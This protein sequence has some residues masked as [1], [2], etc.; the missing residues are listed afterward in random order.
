MATTSPKDADIEKP[1]LDELEY[2]EWSTP[3]PEAFE[4][5]PAIDP[6]IWS[7]PRKYYSLFLCC[8]STFVAAY[9]AGAYTSGI[10]QMSKEWDCSRV[11][12]LLGVTT[13]VAGFAVTP[14]ALAPFSETYGRVRVFCGSHVVFCAM[15]L[16]SALVNNLPGMLVIRF[17][18]GA[19]SSAFSSISGGLISD[20]YHTHDRGTPMAVFSTL[21]LFGTG[22]GPL[23]AGLMIGAGMHWRWIHWV[24]LIFGGAFT[25]LVFLT[26]KET[27][28]SVLLSRRA[29]ALNQFLDSTSDTPVGTRY[30]AHVDEAR[31]SIPILVRTSLTRPF[32]MLVTEPVVFL[33]S[34]WTGLA[35]GL[36]YLFLQGVPV[37]FTQMHQFSASKT[38]TVFISMCG[39][40]LLAF[41]L[42]SLIERYTPHKYANSPDARLFAASTLGLFLPVG[43]FMFF[44]T[45]EMNPAIP[46]S[47]VALVTIGVYTIYLAVFNYF[48]DCYHR[49]SSSALAAQSFCR[50]VLA[51]VFP[52]LVDRMYVSL[53]AKGVGALLGGMAAGE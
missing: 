20:I 35:W 40:S 32:V 27:R 26:M 22:F 36:L 47:A 14:M 44:Y 15:H 11:S 19:S 31:Q 13:F 43:L 45:A 53:G 50:N 21:A 41:V 39:G 6:F 9:S 1:G 12:L 17:F 48:C 34:I 2:L 33:F 23:A 29:R 25:L 8:T 4:P 16:A 28:G 49:Y 42:T 52:P 7:A 46:G 30:K 3:H 18:S 51:G 5:P 38:A 10:P 24:Q 37:V